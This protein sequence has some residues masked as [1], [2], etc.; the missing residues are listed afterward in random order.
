[1]VGREGFLG[2]IRIMITACIQ[3]ALTTMELQKW[4]LLLSGFIENRSII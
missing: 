2:R 3:S 4:M 1:M